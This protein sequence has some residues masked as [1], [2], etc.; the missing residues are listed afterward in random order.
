LGAPFFAGAKL[1]SMKASSQSKAP[2]ASSCERKVRQIL[3]HRFCSVQ[4]F[5]R[6]QHVTGLGYCGGRSCQRAPVRSIQRMPSKT[7]RLLARGR[8]PCDP[9]LSDGSKGSIL[10]H[11]SSVRNFEVAAIGVPPNS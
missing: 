7:S 4:H 9:G 8:P 3:S 6:R 5:N 11:C 2:S 10:A 1:A